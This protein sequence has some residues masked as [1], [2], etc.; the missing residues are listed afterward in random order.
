M[1]SREHRRGDQDGLKDFMELNSPVFPSPHLTT[2]G[3]SYIFP[4]SNEI[5]PSLSKVRREQERKISSARE[6]SELSSGS[7]GNSNENSS[8][9]SDDTYEKERKIITSL[10]LSSKPTRNLKSSHPLPAEGNDKQALPEGE[11]GKRAS[12][13]SADHPFYSIGRSGRY[14]SSPGG[15]DGQGHGKGNG[16]GGGGGKSVVVDGGYGRRSS[17]GI[18]I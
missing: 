18:K 2:P 16:G 12:R 4:A 14:P 11:N 13:S 3:Q 1:D 8:N 10:W 17:F 9:W 15:V 5:S 7:N 6:K